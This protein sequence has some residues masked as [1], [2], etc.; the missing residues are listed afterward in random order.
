MAR[1]IKNGDL[2]AMGVPTFQEFEK[3]PDKYREKFYGREDDT[4][5]WDDKGSTMLKDKVKKHIYEVEGYKCKT[6]EDVQRVAHNMGY[7][8]NE[9]KVIREIVPHAGGWCDIR[10]KYLSHETFNRRKQW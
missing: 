3:N 9:L 10:V 1:D 4:L 5:A 7:K 6:L 8:M 2:K